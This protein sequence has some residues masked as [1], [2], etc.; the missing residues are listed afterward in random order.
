MAKQKELVECRRQSIQQAIAINLQVSA[1]QNGTLLQYSD[2][3]GSA[4]FRRSHF[5][6]NDL[7]KGA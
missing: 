2:R 1:I 4:S 5:S 7:H 6:I 3:P